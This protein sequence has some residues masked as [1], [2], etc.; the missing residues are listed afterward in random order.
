MST[1]RKKGGVACCSCLSDKEAPVAS[2]L[3]CSNLTT[4]MDDAEIAELLASSQVR[5]HVFSA[6][7]IVFHDGDQPHSLYILLR[8]EVHILKDTFSGRRIF[9]S[10]VNEPGD[11]FGE[12]GI[13]QLVFALHILRQFRDV[14]ELALAGGVIHQADQPHPVLGPEFRELVQQGL[15]A[16]LGAQVDMMADPHP[17]RRDQRIQFIRQRTGMRPNTMV[18]G[19]AAYA[20]LKFH[21]KLA[22]ALGN[23]PN[24]AA[25]IAGEIANRVR[26]DAAQ[27]LAAPQQAQARANIG[28]L[29]A[30]EIGN[31]DHDFVADYTAAKA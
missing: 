2:I 6:G 22:A 20:D 17:P 4:G 9:I 11:M 24:F 19:A 14:A 29:G 1:V 23:D 8:G 13:A 26:F 25:T 18:L 27:T 5:R 21:P 12:F 7:E 3:R 10:E 28:A 15:A 16:N 30:V 31:P